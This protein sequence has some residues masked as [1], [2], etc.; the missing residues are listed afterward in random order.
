MYAHSP[1]TDVIGSEG[2][3]SNNWPSNPI[4]SRP[5]T[6]LFTGSC[7]PMNNIITSGLKSPGTVSCTR[8]PKVSS[9]HSGVFNSLVFF[10]EVDVLMQLR[11]A[12]DGYL[13]ER[14]RIPWFLLQRSKPF[15]SRYQIT[16]FMGS[17]TDHCTT[18][19][20]KLYTAG[21]AESLAMIDRQIYRLIGKATT[22]AA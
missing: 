10:S 20:Q 8:M 2:T 6:F 15:T 18:P 12:S 16:V 1:G 19:G 7:P 17:W 13:D 22:L 14:L 9:V 21:N 4:I 3:L 5:L 11:C